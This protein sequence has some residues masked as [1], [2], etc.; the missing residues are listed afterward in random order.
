[1]RTPSRITVVMAY[2]Y[3]VDKIMSQ[4]RADDVK[5]P[6]FEHVMN[7][8]ES[9]SEQDFACDMGHRANYDTLVYLDENGEEI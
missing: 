7:W 2:T 5:N 4:L 8:V 9:A 6:T 1:M 3:D